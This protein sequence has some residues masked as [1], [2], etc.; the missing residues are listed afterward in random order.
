MWIRSLGQTDVHNSHPLQHIS[1]TTMRPFAIPQPPFN[2]LLRII[3]LPESL[4]CSPSHM[5]Y[6]NFPIS[7]KSCPVNQT[8]FSPNSPA[9]QAPMPD[10]RRYPSSVSPQGCGIQSNWTN[11]PVPLRLRDERSRLAPLAGRTA[12]SRSAC[13]TNGPVSLR[14]RDE[15]C[16][17]RICLYTQ[18]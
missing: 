10:H 13:G 3:L 18:G 5:G 12:P 11:G 8:L 9:G 4:Q 1:L 16:F 14:L 7:E 17:A 15:R 6:T 2:S